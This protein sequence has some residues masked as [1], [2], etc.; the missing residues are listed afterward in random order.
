MVLESAIR[1]RKHAIK[2][3]GGLS[4]AQGHYLQIIMAG[5]TSTIFH[6]LQGLQGRSRP[7]SARNSLLELRDGLYCGVLFMFILVI[8]MQN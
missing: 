1:T 7:G 5:G 8:W 3:V 4:M 6:C 2:H